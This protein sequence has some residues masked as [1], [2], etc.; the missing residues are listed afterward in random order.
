MPE[1]QADILIGLRH[2]KAENT[3]ADAMAEHIA[4]MVAAK[5]K[6]SA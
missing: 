6:P 5:L 2:P 4:D 3:G 1:R